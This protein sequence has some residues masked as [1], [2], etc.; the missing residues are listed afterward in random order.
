[1]AIKQ[2]V[3]V[4]AKLALANRHQKLIVEKSKNDNIKPPIDAHLKDY[5]DTLLL[6]TFHSF[7]T[8]TIISRPVGGTRAEPVE[9]ADDNETANSSHGIWFVP[10][11]RTIVWWTN[12]WHAA[13][14]I[15][16]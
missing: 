13:M 2:L 5:F 11:A 4:V 7:K 9:L 16:L 12:S 14:G 15:K 8:D 10:L 6:L 1:L 3:E